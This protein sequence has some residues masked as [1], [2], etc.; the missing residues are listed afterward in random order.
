MSQETA[1]EWYSEDKTATFC[2]SEASQIRKVLRLKEEYPDEIE[3]ERMPEDNQGYIYARVPKDWFMRWKPK[4]KVREYTEE[5][6]SALR[7]RLAE[8][9]SSK[10]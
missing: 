1:F 4:K 8:G 9:K 5:E 3:I 10:K 6:I 7:T 2:S